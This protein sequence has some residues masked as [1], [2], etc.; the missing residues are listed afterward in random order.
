VGHKEGLVLGVHLLAAEAVVLRGLIGRLVVPAALGA[1]PV[2]GFLS[3]G[4]HKF[5]QM[6]VVALAVLLLCRLY[7]HLH[8]AVVGPPL[9]ALQVKE[10]VTALA[11]PNGLHPPNASDA[12]E[13]GC[14]SRV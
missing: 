12:N 7:L 5:A 2:K 1:A 9:D 13:T 8:H 6:I 3:L 11:R 10:A 14:R 4:R